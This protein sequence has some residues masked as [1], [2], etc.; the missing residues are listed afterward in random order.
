MPRHDCANATRDPK[1]G[2]LRCAT[3]HFSGF[4]AIFA[5][6]SAVAQR[7]GANTTG[8]ARCFEGRYA[9]ISGP[10]SVV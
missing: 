5:A 7:S 3:A 6:K 1:K 9:N 4:W 10:F 2:P 8:V